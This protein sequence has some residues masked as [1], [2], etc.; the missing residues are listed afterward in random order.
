MTDAD[1]PQFGG[2]NYVKLGFEDLKHGQWY[3]A[4][5]H[6]APAEAVFFGR[7]GRYDAGSGFM[8]FPEVLDAC[9]EPG[10]GFVAGKVALERKL[11]E[12]ALFGWDWIPE[13]DVDARV[14]EYNRP[15]SFIGKEVSVAGDREQYGVLREIGRFSIV[16][17]PHLAQSF[18]NDGRLTFSVS[19]TDKEV[20]FSSRETLALGALLPS[21]LETLVDVKNRETELAF[22]RKKIEEHEL[23][24]AYEKLSKEQTTQQ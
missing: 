3:R 20:S 18:S 6:H 12:P 8:H 15:F 23:R 2:T 17:N 22:M 19:R 1:K 4:H 24:S 11:R 9:Y 7:F 10:K 5:I 14:A 16:L 13:A 21:T